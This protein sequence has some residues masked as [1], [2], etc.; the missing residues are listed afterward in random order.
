MLTYDFAPASEQK[1]HPASYTHCTFNEQSTDSCSSCKLY[2]PPIEEFSVL[3]TV[4]EESGASVA[5]DPFRGP[6]III[7]TQGEG[8]IEAGAIK[9]E[10]KAGWVYFVGTETG[11]VLRN[12]GTVVMVAYQAFCD[13]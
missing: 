3:K 13:L 9:K 7:C 6:T 11:Y 4:L 12:A 2:D 5:Y 8:T 10:I 1:M